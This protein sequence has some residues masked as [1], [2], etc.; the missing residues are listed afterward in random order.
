LVKENAAYL[1]GGGTTNFHAGLYF[2]QLVMP[3]YVFTIKNF[4]L[5]MLHTNKAHRYATLPTCAEENPAFGKCK[6]ILRFSL[7]V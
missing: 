7:N 6:Y 1:T 5:T 2:M 3:C 4:T